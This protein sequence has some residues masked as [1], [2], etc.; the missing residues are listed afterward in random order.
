MRRPLIA[1]NW[2]MNPPPKEALHHGSENPYRERADIDVIVFPSF[3]DIKACLD[4]RLITGA[5][6]GR[7]EKSGAFTGDISI[8]MLQA[9]GCRYVLCGH[10]D[11]RLHHGET[12]E[13]IAA[14]TVEALEN[15]LHPI[16]CIGETAEEHHA[17]KQEEVIRKQLKGLPLESD[18]TI[19]Y[20]PV[21]A[22]SQGDASK[23]AMSAQE[24][25]AMHAFIRSLL[26]GDRQEQTRI[27]YGGS[28]KAANA[29]ELLSQENIDGGLIGAASLEAEQIARIIA[30]AEQQVS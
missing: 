20:E 6:C 23:K 29:E 13:M 10:S 21:W 4:A 22:I 7:A 26:P 17:K 15:G 3:L 9:A 2:K 19:A 11:R 18:I 8:A 30:V 16:V 12:D 1:C 24:A 27:L 5:Q 28:L 25:E 14:Q